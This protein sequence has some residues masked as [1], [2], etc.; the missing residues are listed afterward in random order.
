MSGRREFLKYSSAA[1]LTACTPIGFSAPARKLPTRVIPGSSERLPI[2]GLGNARV[3]ASGDMQGAALVLDTFIEHGGA[4]VDLSG[5]SRYSVGKILADRGAQAST[6]L[7]NY[8]TGQTLDEMR[9]E[10]WKLQSVQGEGPLDLSMKRDVADLGARADEFHALKKEGLLRHVGIGRPH[11]RFYPAI[12]KLMRAGVVDF[13]QVNYSMMEPD[14]ADEILPLAVDSNIAVVINRPFMNGDYFGLVSGH[15]LP[16]W[17]AEFDCDSWAQ[18]SLKYILSNPAV[19]CVLT[20]TSNP[21]HVIDNLGAG[22]GVMPDEKT[23]SRM[24]GHLL[25]LV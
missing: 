2:V 10:I 19:N 9:P 4:Y 23:R 3:F 11:K 15:E 12:M 6:F 5:T 14:A 16:E 21:K 20:E 17:A 24:R 8:L 18:F 13:I 22:F 7:G 25:K 1:A